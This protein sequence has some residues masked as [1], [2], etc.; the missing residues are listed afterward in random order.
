VAPEA[1]IALTVIPRGV[2]DT[3]LAGIDVQVQVTPKQVR[4]H[5]GVRLVLVE[6]TVRVT[7]FTNRR[8]QY[9]VAR[10]VAWLG[11]HHT[12]HGYQDLFFP[13]PAQSTAVT[14]VMYHFDVAGLQ[15]SLLARYQSDETGRLAF[16]DPNTWRM[17]PRRLGVV[18]IVQDMDTR[19]ILQTAYQRVLPQ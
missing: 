6:D 9:S 7:G 13:L 19:E 11:G 18:A 5:L 15:Q 14:T 8:M 4:P 2:S 16:P 17:Q 1:D 3:G 10:T 12:G